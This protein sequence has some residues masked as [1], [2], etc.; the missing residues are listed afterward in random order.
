MTDREIR[1]L[2]NIRTTLQTLTASNHALIQM[3]K[4]DYKFNTEKFLALFQVYA[5][6]ARDDQWLYDQIIRVEDEID[7]R[8]QDI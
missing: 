6:K 1:L 8:D 3:L 5:Q 2:E 4:E 7:D